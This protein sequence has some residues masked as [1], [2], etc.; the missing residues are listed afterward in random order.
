M[1][2][3]T[4]DPLTA[5]LLEHRAANL[6][7]VQA[8]LCKLQQLRLVQNKLRERMADAEA[9]NSEPELQRLR[10]LRILLSEVCVQFS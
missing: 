4:S 3:F 5:A 9:E 6:K 8:G 1:P 7:T 10:R 2:A